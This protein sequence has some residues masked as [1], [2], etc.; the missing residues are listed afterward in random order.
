[1]FAKKSLAFCHPRHTLLSFPTSLIGNPVFLL[2]P[3]FSGR[4][5]WIPVSAGMTDSG[6]FKSMTMPV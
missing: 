5:R 2:S 3:P 1:M 6:Y 4:R